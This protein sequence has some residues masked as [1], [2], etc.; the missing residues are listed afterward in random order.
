MNSLR[1]FI[2][3]VEWKIV[4]AGEE[5]WIKGRVTEGIPEEIKKALPADRH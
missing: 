5:F 2:Y 3:F 4:F 1:Y